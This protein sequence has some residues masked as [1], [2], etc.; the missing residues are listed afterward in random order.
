MNNNLNIFCLIFVALVA[1][2]SAYGIGESYGS[3]YDSFDGIEDGG[4]Y[5]GSEGY[6]VEE[7]K[8]IGDELVLLV[9]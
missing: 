2:V 1:T 3:R 6:E 9:N 5:G 7:G 4:H 8:E